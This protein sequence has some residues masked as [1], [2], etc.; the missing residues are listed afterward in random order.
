MSTL[1]E[2]ITKV[3]EKNLSKPDLENYRDQ[4]ATIIAQLQ[5]E[6][7]DLEKEQALFM[8]KKGKDETAINRKIEWKCTKDGLR[9]IE[10]KRYI[11]ASKTLM[12]SLR[13]RL[14]VYL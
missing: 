2:V 3:K 5:I 7:A 10:V 12:T 8:G 6:C 14:Y 1:L 11:A 9:L 13:D 4:I